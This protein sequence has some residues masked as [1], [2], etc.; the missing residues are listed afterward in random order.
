MAYE[1]RCRGEVLGHY[2]TP[3]QA[4][5]RAREILKRNADT[6]VEV[7]DLSTGRPYAPAASEEDRSVLAQKIGF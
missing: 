3:D 5:T 2:E 7:I 4:E 6:V 1:L